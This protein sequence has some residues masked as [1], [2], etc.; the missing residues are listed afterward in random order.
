MNEERVVLLQQY[1][2][3]Q[4]E[5]DK[6]LYGGYTHIARARAYR[7]KLIEKKLNRIKERE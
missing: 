7:M 4:K 6:A 3:L 5:R 1:Y 2:K